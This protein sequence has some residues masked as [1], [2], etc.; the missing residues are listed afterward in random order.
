VCTVDAFTSKPFSGNPAAV[1]LLEDDIPDQLKQQIGTEMNISETAFVTKHPDS[2]FK[3]GDS[4]GLRWFTPS[5]EVVLCGHATLAA[6]AVIFRQKLN[7]NNIIRFK[8]LSGELTAEK[9][10][11]RIVLDLPLNPPEPC[12]GEDYKEIIQLV[13]NQRGFI[14]N[15]PVKQCLISKATGKLLV[16]LEDSVTRQE[17]ESITPALDRLTSVK[18]NTVKGVIVTVRGNEDYDFISRYFAPWVGIPED[19]VT[20]SAHTVLTPYWA[21]ILNRPNLHARQCSRRGGDLHLTLGCGRVRVAGEAVIVL[22]GN[23]NI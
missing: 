20:G 13:I 6:A 22:D 11:D 18:Q 17:L 2:D 4:F 10:G 21:D 9:D 1:C 14:K 12:S 5:T 16:R 8:T 15:L 7:V 23:I 3:T 19:P